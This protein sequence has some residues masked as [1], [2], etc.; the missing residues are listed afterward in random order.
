MARYHIRTDVWDAITPTVSPRVS[1]RTASSFE[2]RGQA[3]EEVCG[4]DVS[5]YL[6]N[7][8]PNW[9]VMMISGCDHHDSFPIR[10]LIRSGDVLQDTCYDS[11][12][13]VVNVTTHSIAVLRGGDLSLDDDPGLNG[14]DADSHT[15]SP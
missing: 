2:Q 3:Y 4:T 10:Q 9:Q 11:R 13:D 8:I 7:P 1:V 12:G 5:C 15:T 14:S 6:K